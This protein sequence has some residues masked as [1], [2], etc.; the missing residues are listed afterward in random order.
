MKTFL[1]IVAIAAVSAAVIVA[2]ESGRCVSVCLSSKV[3]K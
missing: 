1:A 3:L 2:H